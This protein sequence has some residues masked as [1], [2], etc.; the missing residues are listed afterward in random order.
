[1]LRHTYTTTLFNAGID[2]KTSQK[3]LR[4]KDFN[5]TMTIYTHLENEKLKD[6]VDKVFN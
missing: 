1:M 4:H 5:T 2:A 3:L 6:T